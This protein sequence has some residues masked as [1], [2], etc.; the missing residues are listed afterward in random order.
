MKMLSK[1]IKELELLK[2]KHGDL[3]VV[4][5]DGYCNESIHDDDSAA[6][7]REKGAWD[8]KEQKCRDCIIIL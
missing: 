3:P 5:S 7:F 8:Y 1:F 4:T 6:T 2:E